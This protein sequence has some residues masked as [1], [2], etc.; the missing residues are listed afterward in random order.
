MRISEPKSGPLAGVKVIDLTLALMGPY[1]AQILCDLGA[2]VV[3]VESADGD[4]TR[5]LGPA[6]AVGHG[7]MFINLN[8]GKRSIVLDLKQP[9]GREALLRLVDQADVF[10]HSMRPSA[11]ERLGLGYAALAERN[12]RLVYLNMYGFGRGGPYAGRPAYD[13][14]IQAM[15]GAAMLQ[16]ELAGGEPSYVATVVADKV[17]GLT[18]AY[19]IMAALYERE[20][21]G[22]GQEIEVPMFETMTSFLFAEHSVG[23]IYDP[24]MGRPVYRRAVQADRRPYRTADG[25]ISVLIYND[26]HWKRFFDLLGNPEWSRDPRFST[27]QSRS[28]HI[29]H[30]LERICEVFASDT[31]AA[32]LD[33]MER[34][35]IPAAPLLT[36][37][38]LTRD[39]HLE[40]VGFWQSISDE[41][42]PMRLAGIPTR[43]SRTPGAI[44]RSAPKLGA[45]GRAVL[46]DAGFTAEE[47]DALKA[48]GTLGGA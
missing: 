26:R 5:Y 30:V 3:K 38:D 24:P 4:T 16:T 45:D 28:E 41:D 35:E 25:Y 37:E 36:T 48:G 46:A 17:G 29:D 1:C 22:Q 44:T 43:F 10:L 27:M 39:P 20:R 21:S 14:V 32:W 19:A 31:T 15:S 8:R 33:K 2:E 9:E 34:A 13:D 40:A 47:I 6:R 23:G 12:P 7:G 11:M 42:G 18:G